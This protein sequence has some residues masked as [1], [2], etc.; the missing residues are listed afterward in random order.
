MDRVYFQYVGLEKYLPSQYGQLNSAYY[1]PVSTTYRTGN[2]TEEFGGDIFISRLYFK[3]HAIIEDDAPVNHDNGSSDYLESHLISFFVEST[4]NCGLRHEGVE[5]TEVY[6]PKSYIDDLEAFLDFERTINGT[7]ESDLIPNYYAYNM[8]YSAE[9]DVKIYIPLPSTYDYC[10]LCSNDY[11]TRIAYSEQKSLESTA[12]EFTSFLVNNYRDLPQ[13]KGDITKLFVHD[14]NLFAHLENTLFQVPTNPKQLTTTDDNVFVGVNDFMAIDPVEVKSVNE[15][16]LGT[17]NQWAHLTTEFGTFFVSEDAVYIL[18]DGLQEISSPS[19]RKFFRDNR[20]RFPDAFRELMLDFSASSTLEFDKADSPASYRGV[21]WIACYDRE[22]HRII[23]HKRDFDI[24]FGVGSVDTPVG[25]WG[26]KNSAIT[27][28]DGSIVLNSDTGWFEQY[29]EEDDEF[30]E[31][32][33]SNSELFQN[34]SLTLSYDVKNK[35]W[36]SF[37]SYLPQYIFNTYNKWYSTKVDISYR[38]TNFITIQVFTSTA[39]LHNSGNYLE[40]YGT[41]QPHIIELVTKETPTAS[42]TKSLEYV[43]LT[44]EFNNT[45]NQWRDIPNVTFTRT[46]LYNDS[47]STGILN[48]IITNGNTDPF[49]S[50]LYTTDSVYLYKADKTWRFNNFRDF[51][52]PTAT[53]PFVSSSWEDLQS[54]YFIDKVPNT[55]AYDTT[56]SQYQ[57]KKFRDKFL[58]MRLYFDP[59]ANTNYKLLT[60]FASANQKESIR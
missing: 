31:L 24:L 36:V 3:K 7:W 16:Y 35:Y 51:V 27:Y 34:K 23:L 41:K 20:L 28:L 13:N 5:E 56:Q 21:G 45:Y 39:W 49:I 29:N 43:G 1:I 58:V 40:Y 8:D 55:I 17:T 25:F 42:V 37:H 30:L 32:E 59:E 6:Y 15:G 18:G 10:S 22:L 44:R 53:V 2:E 19:L 50:I 9:N 57:I 38:P 48:N 60:Q 52:S 46:W 54:G 11:H 4:I 33:L 26:T 47:Q 12:D 14:H